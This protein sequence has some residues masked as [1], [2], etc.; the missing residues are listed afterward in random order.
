MRYSKNHVLW[1]WS[2]RPS[3]SA[4]GLKDEVKHITGPSGVVADMMKAAGE[5]GTK[6]MTDVCDAVV[7]DARIPEYCKSVRVVW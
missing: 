6:W 7:K 5:V 4:G 3:A 1:V 2:D